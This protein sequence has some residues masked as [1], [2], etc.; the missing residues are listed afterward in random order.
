MHAFLSLSLSPS[1]SRLGPQGKFKLW[2]DNTDEEI[3]TFTTTSAGLHNMIRRRQHAST[4]TALCGFREWIF[5]DK[6][7]ALGRFA[8]ATEYAFGTIS[9]RIMTHPV[10]PSRPC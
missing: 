3:V 1:P 7:G 5:S 10:R 6:S 2:A 4:P 9:Q 8:A